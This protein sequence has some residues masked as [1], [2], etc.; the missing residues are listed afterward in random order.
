LWEQVSFASAHP[1]QFITG[2]SGSA[3]D[4][5]PLPAGIPTTP[6]APGA[7]VESMSSWIDGFGFMTMERSGPDSWNVTVWDRD[8]RERNFCTVQGRKSA[9]RIAQVPSGRRQ[10]PAAVSK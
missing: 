8:G 1:T 7:V 4:T 10:A 9:C 2:F 5:T 6:A 3:E